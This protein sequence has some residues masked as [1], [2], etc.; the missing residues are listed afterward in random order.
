MFAEQ[1]KTG[2]QLRGHLF[3]VMESNG[4]LSIPVD[5]SHKDTVGGRK[6]VVD[7]DAGQR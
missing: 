6:R 1:E 5:S 7:D 3:A 2:I 4:I